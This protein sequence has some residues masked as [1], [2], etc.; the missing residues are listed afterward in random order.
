[1]AAR[2]RAKHSHN[3]GANDT[4]ELIFIL[5]LMYTLHRMTQLS[6]LPM[7]YQK[8]MIIPRSKDRATVHQILD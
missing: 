7:T 4:E 5:I 2:M 8:T 1:M 6:N 3:I